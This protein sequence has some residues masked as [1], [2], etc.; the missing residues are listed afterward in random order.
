MFKEREFFTFL[1]P[2]SGQVILGDGKSV[3][4][5]K[6]IGQ[7]KC[8]IN[9]ETLLIDNVHYVPDL[10]E[11]IYSPFV[12]IKQQQHGVYSSFDDGL[13]LKFPSFTTKAIVG[14]NDIYLDA[15][16]FSD[17]IYST[18]N[19][20]MEF[21][22][23][24]CCRHIIQQPSDT[25]TSDQENI[26]QSLRQYYTEAKTK[27][28][29][30]LDVPA[31]FRPRSRL[32]KVFNLFAPPCKTRS[33]DATDTPILGNTS[34]TINVGSPTVTTFSSLSTDSPDSITNPSTNVNV[35]ILRCVDK[36]S[37]S[38]PS[39]IITFTED[40]LR[41]SVGFRRVDTIKSK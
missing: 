1:T 22:V 41:A 7:V 33:A 6:G 36:P 17:N 29:L 2:T 16:P 34:F 23:P 25:G 21:S 8:I 39:K 14:R 19:S 26:L 3:V 12:H 18:L 24:P 30:N 4:N 13:F 9:N 28:Q 10:A 40:F 31:G 32:Q 37:S 20:S 27:R 15:V 11:S 5:I 35:P 38:L